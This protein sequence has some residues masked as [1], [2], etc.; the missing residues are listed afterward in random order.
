M[1]ADLG[2]GWTTSPAAPAAPGVFKATQDDQHW[3]HMSCIRAGY[4]NTPS[5]AQ[6]KPRVKEN[7]L[8]E[9]PREKESNMDTPVKKAYQ[10]LDAKF[11]EDHA[12][13]SPDLNERLFDS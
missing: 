9:M 13:S 10:R 3:S 1:G 5:K 7:V 12:T 2:P 6:P 4:Q 11:T 8:L